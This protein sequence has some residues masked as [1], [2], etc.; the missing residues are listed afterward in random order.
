M[1]NFSIT[2]LRQTFVIAICGLLVSSCNKALDILPENVLDKSHVYQNVQDADA[3]VIGIYG[4]LMNIAPQYII[5][6]ELRGDLM[7]PTENANQYLKQISTFNVNGQ[8]PYSDPKAM[9]KIILDCNDALLNFKLMLRDKRMTQADFDIRYSAVGG[10]RSWLYLQLGIQYGTIAYV[11][12][13]I[14][15]IDAL[16]DQK[17]FTQLNF[18][19]L[20]DS[21]IQFTAALPAKDPFPAGT[22]LVTSVD[23][24]STDKFFLPIR[25]LLG[26]LYLWKGDYIQAA[27]N[28]HVMLNYGDVLYPAKNSEQWYYTY[29][30]GYDDHTRGGNWGNIFNQPY[31][32]RY[33]NYEIMWDLP[34]DKNFA[35]K[36][37][38]IDLFYNQ[39]SSYQLRPSQFAINN[40][41]SQTR[42]DNTPGDYRGENASWKMVGGQPVINKFTSNYTP[43]SPFETNDKWILYRAATLH[44][45]YAEAANRAGRIE[46][47]FAFLNLGLRYTFDPEHLNA[48]HDSRDVTDI[49]QSFGAPFDFDARMGD[50]PSYR[51]PWYRHI[52]IRGRANMP[53]LVIDSAKYFD[54]TVLPRTYL[55]SAA[56]DSL[57]LYM[58]DRL[59]ESGG[60]E[61]AFEG[62]RWPTL[63]RVALRREK[64]APGSGV[65]FLQAK[66]KAKFAAEG[67]AAEGAAVA[68]KLANKTNWFLPFK[69]EQ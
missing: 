10:I 9:Y 55:N 43:T 25:C 67:N 8:N 50:F 3:A 57:K 26:D 34:F 53:I 7:A 40:W 6:N 11:T 47:A 19:Q 64:L 65:R 45:H 4:E 68:A 35:P 13:P 61:L 18:D 69:W 58:E 60:L 56:E 1:R 32:E 38:F 27:T 21:L 52:G 14:E 46:L 63:L 36:N 42:S 48:S 49:E 15:N 37:P 16:K 31:G 17:N 23:G 59:V 28:Y 24:Y 66:I 12:N 2:I 33:S 22:S 44:L 39:G 20:I 30:I 29:K 41:N 62:D 5:L 51:S 54:T